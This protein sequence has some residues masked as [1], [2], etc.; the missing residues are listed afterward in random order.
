MAGGYDQLLTVFSPNGNLF[1]I[2]YAMKAVLN[3]ESTAVTIKTPNSVISISQTKLDN[4][5]YKTAFLDETLVSRIFQVTK[6]IYCTVVGNITDG[7]A[8]VAK[9]RQ[10]ASEF[11][12]NSGIEITT[13]LL[14]KRMGDLN[15]VS[16]QH[17]GRR[18]M[19]VDLIFMGIDEDNKTNVYKVE[20]SGRYLG[21][22][23][24]ASGKLAQD[25]EDRITK[26]FVENRERLDDTNAAMMTAV[27]A[28]QDAAKLTFTN[29][30]IEGSIM[31]VEGDKR[32]YRK[33][34]QDDIDKVLNDI[35]QSD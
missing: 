9:A 15:Q 26:E 22:K 3:S 29:S 34:T 27:R 8:L 19:G 30:D 33:L 1:Q 21:Y 23:A 32:V 14:A 35:A 17:A 6:Y 16:T 4:V 28:L 25:T 5:I 10:E 2:E 18:I 11:R 12:Y 13:S 24:T 20:P 31:Y 7:K